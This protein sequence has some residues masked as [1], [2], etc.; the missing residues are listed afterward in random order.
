MLD[1][2]EEFAI[3]HNYPF[4]DYVEDEYAPDGQRGVMYPENVAPD[5]DMAV[6][7]LDDAWAHLQNMLPKSDAA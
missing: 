4:D 2:A 1:E 7:L 6:S 3:E 5:L